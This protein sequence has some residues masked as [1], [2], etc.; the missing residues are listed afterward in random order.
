MVLLLSQ[1]VTKA[2][3][4][5]PFVLGFQTFNDDHHQRHG[6]SVGKVKNKKNSLKVS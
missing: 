1:L 2:I 6:R 5:S 4:G 3:H